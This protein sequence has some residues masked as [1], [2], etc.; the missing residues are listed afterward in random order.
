MEPRTNL[1]GAARVQQEHDRLGDLLNHPIHPV[2]GK[3]GCQGKAIAERFAAMQAALE[4]FG[5]PENYHG[6]CLG[7]VLP[8]E[9][10]A[11]A[12]AAIRGELRT[13]S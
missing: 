4:W 2:C 11:F 8:D 10:A 9:A 7:G 1:T 3:V 12:Q 5:D 6:A 13:A